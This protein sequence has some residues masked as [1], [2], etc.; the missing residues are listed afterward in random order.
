MR[1]YGYDKADSHVKEHKYFRN[2]LKE[3]TEACFTVDTF[4]A[5]ISEF[6]NEWFFKHVSEVDNELAVF[7]L[8]YE[9]GNLRST[10]KAII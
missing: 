2:K 7:L 6:L 3:I 8:N 5:T 9:P 10:N 1:E 4:N